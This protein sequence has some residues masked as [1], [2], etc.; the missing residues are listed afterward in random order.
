MINY[1]MSPRI[2]TGTPRHCHR[3]S[4]DAAEHRKRC[5]W[6]LS[7]CYAR[8]SK[9]STTRRRACAHL[10]IES[11]VLYTRMV[12]FSKQ[13]KTVDKVGTSRGIK[14]TSVAIDSDKRPNRTRT[15]V[16]I[17]VI[18]RRFRRN[19][20]GHPGTYSEAVPNS[21]KPKLNL[22]ASVTATNS[23]SRQAGFV[24]VWEL[25]ASARVRGNVAFL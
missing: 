16:F 7:K 13:K 8:S 11:I 21:A 14:E 19:R 20:R 1:T 6:M 10:G 18:P 4:A 2:G 5:Q 3:L 17:I 24:L 15:F 22:G 12:I 9:S 25:V 23:K